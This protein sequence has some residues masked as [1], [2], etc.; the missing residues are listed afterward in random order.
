MILQKRYNQQQGQRQ[1]AE[2]NHQPKYQQQQE[3]TI[4]DKHFFALLRSDYKKVRYWCDQD[5]ANGTNLPRSCCEN[6]FVQCN[7]TVLYSGTFDE[8]DDGPEGTKI[9]TSSGEVHMETSSWTADDLPAQI[10]ARLVPDLLKRPGCK[11]QLLQWLHDGGTNW[12]IL[13][14]CTVIL[15]KIVLCIVLK[16]EIREFACEIDLIH[17]NSAASSSGDALDR[18][19]SVEATPFMSQKEEGDI[20]QEERC[21]QRSQI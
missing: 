19:F 11:N 13:A 10:A 3:I 16:N 8:E 21:P 18:A 20:H 6:E 1:R 17:Q 15:V 14:Y 5:L 4:R 12:F 7:S 9:K 2:N